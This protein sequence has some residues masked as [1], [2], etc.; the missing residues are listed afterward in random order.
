M[1]SEHFLVDNGKP[2]IANSDDRRV[3]PQLMHNL[4]RTCGNGD[5][6]SCPVPTELL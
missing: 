1:A 5:N 6:E 4:I 3:F 2:D